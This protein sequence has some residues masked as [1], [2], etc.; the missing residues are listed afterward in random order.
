[1]IVAL[2][3]VLM[4]SSA[5]LTTEGTKE[6]RYRIYSRGIRVGELTSTIS[7]QSGSGGKILKFAST[8]AIKAN[9]V[10]YSYSME[11]REEALVGE[12]G[13]FSYLRT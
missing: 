12:N 11:N 9:F 7:P 10:V 6:S 13:A 1:M 8:C 4:G 5:A 2:S 3:I